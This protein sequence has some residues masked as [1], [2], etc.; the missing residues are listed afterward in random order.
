MFQ[1]AILTFVVTTS[2]IA[3]ALLIWSASA[4]DARRGILWSDVKLAFILV[5]PFTS[6]GLLLLNTVAWLARGFAI[7][8]A[9]RFLFLVLAGGFLGTLLLLPLSDL[10]TFDLLIGTAAGAFSAG[11]WAL[12]N[13][14]QRRVSSRTKP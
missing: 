14:G 5:S 10:P 6:L 11:I 7:E 1:R 2:A 12:L 4:P 13:G 3:V 8:G 9:S